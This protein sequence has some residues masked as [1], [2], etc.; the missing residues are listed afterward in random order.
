MSTRWNWLWAIGIVAFSFFATLTILDWID[1]SK[2][3]N[4]GKNFPPESAAAGNS[5]PKG[6]KVELKAPYKKMEGY[7]FRVP[8]PSLAGVGDTDT[9]M[10]RSPVVMCEDDKTIGPPHTP[11]AEIVRLGL[12]RFSN[13]R[14]EV[15]FSSTDNSN[16]NSNGRRYFTVVPAM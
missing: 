15:V 5:C 12:G 8:A 9:E 2:T 3:A 6:D 16:P 11:F 14:A 10:R 4:T 1:A 13:Y 7:A